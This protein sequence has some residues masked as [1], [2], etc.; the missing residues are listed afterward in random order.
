MKRVNG[1]TL[2]E[3]LVVIAIIAILAAILFPVFATAREKA[4]QSACASNEK[5]IG[6]ALIQYTQDYDETYPCYYYDT[7]ATPNAW[8]PKANYEPVALYPYLKSAGV[9]VCPSQPP[10][11]TWPARITSTLNFGWQMPGSAVYLPTEYLVNDLIAVRLDKSSFAPATFVPVT[12]SSLAAPSTAIAMGEVN[13]QN[14]SGAADLSFPAQHTT[15]WYA[16]STTTAIRVSNLHNNGMNAIYC[17][18]HSKWLSATVY[19]NPGNAALWYPGY[20]N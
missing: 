20:A 2:I 7:N 19:E 1:F 18:G 11:E 10:A 9:W 14:T 3:L 8:V 17:D 15:Q 5:Q 12:M 16:G 6:L 13:S 4:R